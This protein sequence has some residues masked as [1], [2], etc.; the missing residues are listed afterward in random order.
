MKFKEYL[1]NLNQMAKED[2]S[3]L[4]LT[5]VN[6]IDSE[7]NGYDKVVYT[8]SLG[9]LD[10]DGEGIFAEEDLEDEESYPINCICIN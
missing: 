5:V 7:G 10:E 1:E 4:E 6:A 2:P 8:P 3:I 9:H